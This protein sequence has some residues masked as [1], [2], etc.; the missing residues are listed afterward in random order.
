MQQGLK[1]RKRQWV[2]LL[3]LSG[4]HATVDMSVG[5]LAV[6][7]PVVRETYS[8][9]LTLGVVL[10]SAH[11]LACNGVQLLIGHLR[12]DKKTPLLISVGLALATLFCFLGLLPQQASA[13]VWVFV[14]TIISGIGVAFVSSGRTTSGPPFKRHPSGHLFIRFSH[15]WLCGQFL[16]KLVCF[17][18]GFPLGIKRIAAADAVACTTLGSI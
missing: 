14:L 1:S 2:D 12:A 3:T 10:L 15:G 8:L 17:R 4:L 11:S 6:L 16:W 13:V 18:F 7:L 9:S 5:M